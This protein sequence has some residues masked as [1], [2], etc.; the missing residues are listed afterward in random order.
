[1]INEIV[2]VYATPSINREV[3]KE[4]ADQARE[5]GV[6]VTRT[7]SHLTTHYLLDHIPEQEKDGVPT[8]YP[9]E[10]LCGLLNGSHFVTIS[11]LKEFLAKAKL[12]RGS[13]NLEEEYNPPKAED[14]K[15]A[16]PLS[17]PWQ[18]S[19]SR[20][21]LFKDINFIVLY[22]GSEVSAVFNDIV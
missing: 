7:W 21:G 10:M 9:I 4:L 18:P 16:G 19:D 15:P 2:Y 17:E 22:D 11:W 1:M 12:P 5:F 8:V 14:F 13:G 6:R 20:Q 3:A